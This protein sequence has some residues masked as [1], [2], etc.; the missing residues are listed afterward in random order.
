MGNDS[1]DKRT[2]VLVVED[3]DTM[4]KMLVRSFLLRGHYRVDEAADLD[5]AMH[6]LETCTYQVAL[7]DIMLAGAMDTANRDGS[8]VL[9][10]IRDLEEGTRA[11]VLSGQDQPQLARDFLKEFGA[12]D[13]IA[14]SEPG[15]SGSGSWWRW[16]PPKPRPAR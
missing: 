8:K 13:Y 9:E 10:K 5:E 16:W 2:R 12:A 14:K 3:V 11:I 1:L 15:R 4:R 6:A 7:V